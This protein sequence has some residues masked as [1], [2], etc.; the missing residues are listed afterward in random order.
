MQK[1]N[2][3]R[4]KV[5]AAILGVLVAVEVFLEVFVYPNLT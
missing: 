5:L 4:V 3:S 1:S 2:S